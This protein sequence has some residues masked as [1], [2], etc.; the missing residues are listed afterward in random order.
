MTDAPSEPPPPDPTPTIVCYRC[1]N[2][3][4]HCF[5]SADEA[6]PDMC[7]YCQDMTTWKPIEPN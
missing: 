4:Q 6:P 1:P 5:C 2:C 3:G 7:S